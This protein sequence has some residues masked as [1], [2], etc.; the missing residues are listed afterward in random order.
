MAKPVAPGPKKPYSAP[1]LLVYGTIRD[2]TQKI[3]R[4]GKSDSGRAPRNTTS[5]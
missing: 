4:R 5:I 1:K 3:G 2:L